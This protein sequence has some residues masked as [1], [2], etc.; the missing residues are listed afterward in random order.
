MGRDPACPYTLTHNAPIF[1]HSSEPSNG[2]I[3]M[4]T[5]ANVFIFININDKYT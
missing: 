4:I 5:E 3:T 2:N 1:P